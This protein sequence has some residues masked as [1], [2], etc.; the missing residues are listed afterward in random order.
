MRRQF[1]AE[2]IIVDWEADCFFGCYSL[3][4]CSLEIFVI[5]WG[6]LSNMQ[7]WEMISLTWNGRESDW[8]ITVNEKRICSIVKRLSQKQKFSL[9]RTVNNSIL[10]HFFAQGTRHF[11]KGSCL[12]FVKMP[13]GET[14]RSNPVLRLMLPLPTLES[15]TKNRYWKFLLWS[16]W[17]P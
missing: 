5:P 11:Q 6:F 17:W 1:A 8:R 4:N 12:W 14:V 16:V 9:P 10:Q 2:A 15:H 7:Q 3:N 13:D